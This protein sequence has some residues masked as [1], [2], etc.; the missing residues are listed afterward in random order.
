MSRT[1]TRA[2]LIGGLV[3]ACAMPAYF[4]WLLGSPYRA[5][6]QPIFVQIEH[7]TPAREVARRLAEAGIIR[8]S[9]A[10][11]MLSYLRPGRS[12]KAGEY[13]FDR[14]LSAREV[15][16]KL[17]RG[18]VY[19]YTVTIPE[20]FNIFDLAGLMAGAGL[21]SRG[22]VLEALEDSALIADLDPLARTLEGYVFPDTYR[23]TRPINARLMVGTMV[24]RFRTVYGELARRYPAG[25]TVHEIVTMASLVEKETGAPGERPL[26]AS[27]FYNRLNKGMRLQ[28]DPTV[29]YAALLAG[30]YRGRIL[31]S[32]LASKSP[33]NTYTQASLPPGPI[34]N[35]GRASLEAALAP[36]PSRY[37]YFVGN[38]VN[39]HRFSVTLG[40]HQRNVTAYRRSQK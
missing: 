27:V 32:D 37:M 8:S 40:E 2:L 5:L 38:G 22:E 15:L 29:I 34:A 3:L 39:G 36:V 28:C 13:C 20:G 33:Y 35:P 18:D 14:P 24:S 7:N 11:L 19:Y 31:Q 25:R 26:V 17:R 30:R 6:P 21:V 1:A 16:D 12:L 4:W 10:F 23:F 9:S